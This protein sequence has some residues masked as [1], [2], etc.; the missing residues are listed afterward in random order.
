MHKKLQTVHRLRVMPPFL[1]QGPNSARIDPAELAAA[2]FPASPAVKLHPES[3]RRGYLEPDATLT[4]QTDAGNWAVLVE[5]DRTERSHKQID[6]LRRYDRWLLD[7]WTQGR[8]SAHAT[9]PSVLF[10]TARERPLRRLVETA[11]QTFTAWDGQKHAGSREGTHPARQRTV[12]TSRDSI[13]D[14]DWTMLR[15][16]SLPPDY[17]DEPR[18][19]PRAPL[20]VSAASADTHVRANVGAAKCAVC[21]H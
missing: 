19:V 4:A 9:P 3:S 7:G 21:A 10:Q 14:G 17:R 16:P 6:R 2:G 1:W 8:F 5:S 18:F 12:F 11:D 20:Q 13:L 15:T